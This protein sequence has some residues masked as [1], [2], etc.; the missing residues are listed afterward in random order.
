MQNF[1]LINSISIIKNVLMPIK[2]AKER[3]VNKGAALSRLQSLGIQDK[4]KSYPHELSGG[5]RQRVA[6]ARALMNNPKVILA[7]EP[8]GSLDLNTSQL[9]MEILKDMNKNGTTILLVAHQK[10]LADQC[11]RSIELEDGRIISDKN[12]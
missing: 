3:K 11:N 5:Q 7:D 8:T 1:G 9:I 10:E 2:K 6:I 4:D 12:K